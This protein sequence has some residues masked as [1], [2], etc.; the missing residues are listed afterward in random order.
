M[1]NF[2]FSSMTWSFIFSG[3]ELIVLLKKKD[4]F[5][6][7]SIQPPPFLSTADNGKTHH[8]H[9]M[10]R[11][12]EAKKD[13]VSLVFLSITNIVLS[14]KPFRIFMLF[15]GFL[16]IPLHKKDWGV[17]FKIRSKTRSHVL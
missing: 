2:R 5:S 13:T 12:F 17:P 1:A 10:V 7:F 14:V 6:P 8:L 9:L 3:V 11:S 16:Y 15:S 4:L